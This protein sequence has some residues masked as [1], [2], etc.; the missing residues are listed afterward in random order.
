MGV[1]DV[2]RILESDKLFNACLKRL[3]LLGISAFVEFLNPTFS[4][5]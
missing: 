5:H 2:G 1:F 4:E 3:G